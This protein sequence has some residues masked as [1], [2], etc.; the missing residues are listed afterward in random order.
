LPWSQASPQNGI[1]P[2]IPMKVLSATS[3]GYLF[4]PSLKQ[5]EHEDKTKDCMSDKYLT[6]LTA[7]DKIL[8]I[9]ASI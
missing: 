5:K 9:N 2:K 3:K 7:N 1:P 4:H 8:N 6:F